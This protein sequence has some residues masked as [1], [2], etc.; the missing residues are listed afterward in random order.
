MNHTIS[1]NR[2]EQFLKVYKK[3]KRTYHKYF[4]LYLMPNRT[5]TNRLGIR[6]GKKLA[7]AVKRNRLRRL[8]REVYRLSEDDFKIGYDVVIV[9]KE[10]SIE[11]DSFGSVQ[12]I[13]SYMFAKSGLCIKSK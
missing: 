11:L 6:V 1:L 3:G 12:P 5:E 13:I 8:I 9:A 7:K 4:T 2:N 10:G